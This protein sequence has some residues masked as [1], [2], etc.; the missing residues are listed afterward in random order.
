MS[1]QDGITSLGCQ[2]PGPLPTIKWKCP[3]CGHSFQT[4]LKPYEEDITA[5][6]RII[7]KHIKAGCS[8]YRPQ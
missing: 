5:E 2:T 7:A 1:E 3:A 4:L 8:A 6:E